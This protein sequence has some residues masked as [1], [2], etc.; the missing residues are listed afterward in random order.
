MT[1][2]I[3]IAT[4]VVLGLIAMIGALVVI[5]STQPR[6]HVATGSVVVTA[7]VG[8]VWDTIVDYE[9]MPDWADGVGRIERMPDRDGKPVYRETRDDMSLTF[10]FEEVE[11]PRRLVVSLGDAA[12]NFGGAWTYEL[13]A[14]GANTEV[15]VTEEG[16][17]EPAVFRFVMMVI[18][19]D[20][21][22]QQFLA[23]LQ[24]KHA[25]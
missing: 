2:L 1:R 23:A 4:F 21:T 24:A 14:Q 9:S 20:A 13:E 11:R 17:I 5:G 22:I 19:Y 12:G 6:A 3:R 18:G 8:V 15:T 16:W 10:V 7:S 25:S